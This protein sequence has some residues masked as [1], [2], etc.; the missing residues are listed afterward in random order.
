MENVLEC[1]THYYLAWKIDY[2]DKPI[3]AERLKQIQEAINTVQKHIQKSPEELLSRGEI[4]T[5]LDGAEEVDGSFSAIQDADSECN[6]YIITDAHPLRLN[7]IMSPSNMYA[8]KGKT[9][10]H[11]YHDLNSEYKEWRVV[12]H[13][14]TTEWK[15][16]PIKD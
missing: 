15:D 10:M 4:D 14:S 12:P 16:I 8:W 11:L 2:V 3:Y 5:L 9:L 1:L 7:R 13:I 6:P